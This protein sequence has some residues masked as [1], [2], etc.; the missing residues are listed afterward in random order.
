[1]FNP[2]SPHHVH[3]FAHL[4]RLFAHLD[5]GVVAQENMAAMLSHLL[6]ISRKRCPDTHT[7]PSEGTR[8]TSAHVSMKDANDRRIEHGG[9]ERMKLRSQLLQSLPQ[10]R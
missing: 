9:L 2:H 1:V 7:L 10:A 6:D 3:S 4:D 5:R 8:T